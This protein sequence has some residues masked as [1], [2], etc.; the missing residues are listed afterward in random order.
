MKQPGRQT[1]ESTLK[2]FKLNDCKP[3]MVLLFA[4]SLSG[5]IVPNKD[6]MNLKSDVESLKKETAR[7]QLAAGIK[8]DTNKSRLDQIETEIEYLSRDLKKTKASSDA[9]LNAM[10]GEV[11]AFGGRFEEVRHLTQRDS[12]KNRLFLSA[13][14]T[15]LNSLEERLTKAEKGIEELGTQL[16]VLKKNTLQAKEREKPEESSSSDLYK[17]G[18]D[19][20]KKGNTK[21]AREIFTRY[22]KS[23]PDGPLANNA[24]FWIGESFYDEGDFERAIIEYDDVIK[25]YPEGGKVPAALLKQGMAFEKIKDLKTAQALYNKLIKD[26]P[27]SDESKLARK[28]TTKSKKKP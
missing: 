10:K 23:F 16:E 21:E 22:L 1:G 20:I 7:L 2:R 6:L 8:P 28:M 27:D 19:A 26:F 17:T 9:S 3:C 18:L 14:D 11:Q 13:A 4:V 15:R 24:Q 12:D 25:K 5:C